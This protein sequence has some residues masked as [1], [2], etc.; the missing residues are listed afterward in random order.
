M[1]L[2]SPFHPPPVT[3]KGGVV[4]MKWRIKYGTQELRKKTRGVMSYEITWR[5]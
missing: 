2:G 5:G 1:P 4:M 3:Q